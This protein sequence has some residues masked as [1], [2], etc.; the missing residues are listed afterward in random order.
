[1]TAFSLKRG[2]KIKNG[3]DS[4]SSFPAL[5]AQMCIERMLSYIPLYQALPLMR[6]CTM[7]GLPFSLLI[8]FHVFMQKAIYINTVSYSLKLQIFCTNGR[9]LAIKNTSLERCLL[10]FI[11][12][13]T[14]NHQMVWKSQE[15]ILIFFSGL[16]EKYSLNL[17]LC[18]VPLFLVRFWRLSNNKEKGLRH[19]NFGCGPALILFK[20]LWL[21]S[22]SPVYNKRVE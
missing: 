4:H 20:E 2:S 5:E 10:A 17:L 15:N 7:L 12:C 11:L 13:D 8:H 6:F 3:C 16:W 18:S 14:L 22:W 9:I 19:L 21:L 1:M